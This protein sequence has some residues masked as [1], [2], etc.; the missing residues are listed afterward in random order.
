[1]NATWLLDVGPDWKAPH[2]TRDENPSNVFD[3]RL[4]QAEALSTICYCEEF[5]SF[6]DVIQHNILHLLHDVITEA[7]IA[8]DEMR[9][10]EAVREEGVQ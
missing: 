4:A 9:E 7:R 10:R 2:P 6:N 8:Y 1:M 5:Q 3:N